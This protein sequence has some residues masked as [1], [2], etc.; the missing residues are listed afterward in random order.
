ML[1][2]IKLETEALNIVLTNLSS[3][4][5]RP[6]LV[7][8]I[9]IKGLDDLCKIGLLE[10]DSIVYKRLCNTIKSTAAMFTRYTDYNMIAYLRRQVK[11]A[12]RL[13]RKTV[14]L[15]CKRLAKDQDNTLELVFHFMDFASQVLHDSHAMINNSSEEEISKIVSNRE[16][17]F[18]LWLTRF[19]A[20][21]TYVECHLLAASAK[22]NAEIESLIVQGESAWFNAV[23]VMKE[24]ERGV[25]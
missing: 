7:D 23:T 8:T 9:M 3:F 19:H 18:I 15:S 12:M 17:G 4:H 25:A 24:L 20:A 21:F 5:N 13:R 2:N 14:K 11:W 10:T 22:D 1:K 16:F 6:Y